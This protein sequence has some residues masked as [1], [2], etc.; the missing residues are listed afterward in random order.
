MGETAK[1]NRPPQLKSASSKELETFL[2]VKQSA[3]EEH[4]APSEQR[5]QSQPLD[6]KSHSEADPNE[7]TNCS[8]PTPIPKAAT[9]GVVGIAFVES[10]S[11]VASL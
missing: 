10:G 3:A 8:R 7:P 2:S 6:E 4:R 9:Q 1:P 5:L 11:D